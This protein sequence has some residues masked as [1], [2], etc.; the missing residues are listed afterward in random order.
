[1]YEFPVGFWEFR[2]GPSLTLSL[3]LCEPDNKIGDAGVTALAPSLNG[4][5]ALTT[6]YLGGEWVTGCAVSKPVNNIR[7]PFPFVVCMNQ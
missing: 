2:C 5:T 6:L 4:L 3:S 7:N 1:M